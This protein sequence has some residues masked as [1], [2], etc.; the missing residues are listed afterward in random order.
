MRPGE[1]ALAV[2]PRTERRAT[3]VSCSSG[4]CARS[5]TS[6]TDAPKNPNEARARG[7]TAHI[8]LD[9][10]FRPGLQ[11]LEQFSHAIVLYWMHEARRDLV[12]QAPR[13]SGTAHGTFALRSPVRPNPIALSVVRIL[14]VDADAGRIDIDAIDCLDGTPSW[15]S[16][17]TGRASMRCRTR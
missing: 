6:R 3:R 16:S 2:D 13:H 14:K 8:E 9:A 10:P 1:I 12:V 4:A 17:R 11:G 5:W 7:G 15:T